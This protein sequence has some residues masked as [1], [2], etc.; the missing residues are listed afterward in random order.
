MKKLCYKLKLIMSLT[1]IPL[2]SQASIVL[3]M[4]VEGCVGEEEHRMRL[5]LMWMKDLNDDDFQ[6]LFRAH[7]DPNQPKFA[8]RFDKDYTSY[9][10]GVFTFKIVEINLNCTE[11][12]G[13]EHSQEEDLSLIHI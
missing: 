4:K 5:L 6:S 7:I 3:D 9:K 8:M 12:F 1:L 11:L 10:E 2:Q 13:E